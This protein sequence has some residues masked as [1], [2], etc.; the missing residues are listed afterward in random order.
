MI[1]LPK[2]VID[3]PSCKML[4]GIVVDMVTIDSIQ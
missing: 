2:L 4:T 1:G 3:D